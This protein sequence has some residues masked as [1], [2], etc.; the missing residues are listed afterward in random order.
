VKGQIAEIAFSLLSLIVAALL[1]QLRAWVAA[2]YKNEKYNAILER[3]ENTVE[4]AVKET[5]QTFLSSLKEVKPGDFKAAKEAA[6]ANVKKHM[7]VKG[8][9]ELKTILGHESVEAVEAFVAGRLEAAIHDM[10]YR[11]QLPVRSGNTSP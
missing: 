10:K 1:A 6:L 9:E 7:G 4:A 3:L 11:G 8:Y 2:K 5:E